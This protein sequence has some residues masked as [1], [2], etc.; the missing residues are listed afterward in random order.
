MIPKAAIEK[1]IEGGWVPPRPYLVLQF[2]K[3]SKLHAEEVMAMM[4]PQEIA[5]DL[6]F[7][8]ALGK[9]LRWPLLGQPY[10]LGNH[11]C[12]R[13]WWQYKAIK[14]YDLILTGGD[15]EAF[16]KELLKE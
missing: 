14:F 3:G 16:W 6:S 2:E 15:T 12:E 8:Q 5:L 10:Y 11:W 7:W 13:E 9:A 4:L 1:S